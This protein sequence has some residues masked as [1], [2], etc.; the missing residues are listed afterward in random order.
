LLVAW[1]S[2][3]LLGAFI[4]W[5]TNVMTI[6]LIFR[7]RRPWRVGPVVIQGVIPRRRREIAESLART[8]TQELLSAEALFSAVDTPENRRALVA[9]LRQELGRRLAALPAF[10]FKA[11]VVER[12]QDLAG[13]EVLRYVE[14]LSRDPEWP[15]RVLA[16]VPLER[17][18]VERI[19]AFD[20]VEFERVIVRLS[21][22]EL[23]QIEWLGGIL[24]FVVG[25]FLPFVQAVLS[26]GH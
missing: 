16:R 12:I 21:H 11:A 6:R 24:G 25:L 1:L 26:L 8:V 22:R 9:G 7:P 3:A 2:S 23:R 17:L 15:R 18:I 19:E 20:L 4:G 5:I 10:P 13:R 14:Q